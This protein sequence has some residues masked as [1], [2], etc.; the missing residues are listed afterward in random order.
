MINSVD[1][2]DVFNRT[3]K[4][5]Q[6]EDLYN[7]EAIGNALSK[8]DDPDENLKTAILMAEVLNEFRDDR[9]ENS[10]EFGNEA[11]E[12]ENAPDDNYRDMGTSPIRNRLL[13]IVN[14][15]NRTPAIA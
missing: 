1:Q 3:T 11:E 6:L 2:T 5:H 14:L 10:E 8:F 12:A 7:M 13:A 15:K 4:S 9:M